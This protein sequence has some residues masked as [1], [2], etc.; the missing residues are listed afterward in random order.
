MQLPTQGQWWS[1]RATQR[2]QTAQCLERSG[3]RTR[4]ALQKRAGS[5]AALPPASDS[6]RMVRSLSGRSARM[7]PGSARHDRRN[8]YH[9]APELSTNSA[10][11]APGT[12]P[13]TNTSHVM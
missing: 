1:K 5:K 3:R 4:Q 12:T 2:L 10:E 11:A 13:A 9:S 8:V 6:S 7:T